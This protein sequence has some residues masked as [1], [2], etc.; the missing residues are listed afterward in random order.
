MNP[1]TKRILKIT[2]Q[3]IIALPS[4]SALAGLVLG[5]TV[6]HPF[7]RRVT[8]RQMAQADQVFASLNATREDFLVRADDGILLRGWKVKP[9]IL[10]VTGFFSCTAD[11]TIA[12]SC[13]PMPN[14]YW[15][16]DTVW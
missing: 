11:R 6:L 14:S 1:A 3:I 4:L 13:F 15:L 8:V 2:V 16:P 5:P 12:R 7:R 9:A 10:T